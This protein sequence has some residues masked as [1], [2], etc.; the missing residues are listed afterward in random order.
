MRYELSTA[1][2]TFGPPHPRRRLGINI[3]HLT[4]GKAVHDS[5]RPLK[6]AL[7][8][9]G[10]KWLRFPGGEKSDAYLWSNPPFTAPSPRCC[11]TGP[12]QAGDIFR[13]YIADDGIAYSDETLG[14]D[15]YVRLCREIDAEPII[16]VAYDSY[17]K[18]VPATGTKP[19]RSE[20]LENART[21]VRYAN[22]T[23]RYGIRYWEIG[24][25]SYLD[26]Y[27]GAVTAE[28]Y[29]RDVIEFSAAMKAED[30]SIHIGV[31]GPNGVDALG[32]LDKGTGNAWWRTVLG[33][34]S[35]SIDF[36]SV[37]DYPCMEWMSYDSYHKTEHNFA[38][39][40]ESARDCIGSFCNSH[41][42]ARI[43]IALTETNSA[44]WFGH[45]ENLGWPHENT[46]GHAIVLFE[47]LATQLVEPKLL[48]TLVWNTRWIR[49]DEL[50]TPQLWDALK[51]DNTPNPTGM[52][53]E[54]F[55][56]HLADRFGRI[57][58]K[59]PLACFFS[60]SDELRTFFIVNRDFVPHTASVINGENTTIETTIE[61]LAGSGPD[62]TTP[63]VSDSSIG[64]QALES[65][66]LPPVSITIVTIR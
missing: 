26:S 53:L 11:R 54:I 47:M 63:S 25:E 8:A 57:D 49:N 35:Q 37:H 51:P 56:R 45:P 41:D 21:W 59:G 22:K 33:L 50:G 18:E 17:C 46:L 9:M 19:S 40:L 39:A 1:C 64:V 62:D 55:G 34:A 36:L 2:V 14:F 24:N 44:D 7:S 15:E 58:T 32:A 66:E 6:T 28:T 3:N 12:R 30:E 29:A 4:D 38:K 23:M 60:E 13:R 48:C 61:R 31:N 5:N 42:A 65:I 43:Q 16:V 20:L 52:V 10:C 27:N